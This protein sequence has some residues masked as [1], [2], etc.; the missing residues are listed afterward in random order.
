MKLTPEMMIQLLESRPKRIG[1]ILVEQGLLSEADLGTA[2][3]Y[4]RAQP[5]KRIGTVLRELGLVGTLDFM[6]ALST[7]LSVVKGYSEG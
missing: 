2:L 4:Q 3:V 6:E 1:E 5:G 7:N